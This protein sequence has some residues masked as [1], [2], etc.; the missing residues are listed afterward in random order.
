M[1]SAPGFDK[2]GWVILDKPVEMTSRQAVTAIQK[3]LD[4]DKAG[5][6]GT[7]DP[8][9]TGILPIALGEATKAIQYVQADTKRYRLRIE[10]G[11]EYNT[12]DPEGEVVETSDHRPS[13]TE[14]RDA[15]NKYIGQIEQIPPQYSAIKVKGQRAYKLARRGKKLDLDPR[16]VHI[17]SIQPRKFDE[18]WAELEV[19]CGKGTYMRALARDLG[20]DL[21]CYAHAANIRRLGVGPFDE[22]RAVTLNQLEN[23]PPE[24]RDDYIHP[25]IAP[26]D[27]I[28]ALVVT[29]REAWKIR[30]GQEIQLLTRQD[31]DRLV[32]AGFMPANDRIETGMAITG[33]NQIVAFVEVQGGKISP[34][35]VLH[36][37]G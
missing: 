34:D 27:D 6:A 31:K 22:G 5:H 4:A 21:G 19:S 25:V 29:D 13:Q 8:L 15:V 10:W 36:L 11:S 2:N 24:K 32:N 20:R 26:L 14:V 7:L 16:V 23:T 9:A 18:N 3:L 33:N 28:P 1:N 12:D 17:H 30:H 35:S 37:T